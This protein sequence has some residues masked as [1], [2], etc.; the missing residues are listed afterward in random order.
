[1]ICELTGNGGHADSHIRMLQ[2]IDERSSAHMQQSTN[3]VD[4]IARHMSIFRP[5]EPHND[6]EGQAASRNCYV[7]YSI[8][9]A[10]NTRA[11]LEIDKVIFFIVI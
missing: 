9:Q 8:C 1:M 10:F 11:S 2:T 3:L 6:R 7:L 5:D 4:F